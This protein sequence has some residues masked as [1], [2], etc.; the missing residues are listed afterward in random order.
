ME[1]PTLTVTPPRRRWAVLASFGFTAGC[2]ALM[3]MD[4][5]TVSVLSDDVYSISD[6]QL[7]WI[8][9]ISLLTVLPFTFPAAYFLV[10][11]N[12]SA[13]LV[14]VILNVAGA[15]LRMVAVYSRSYDLALVSSVLIGAAASIVICSYTP[16][17]ERWFPRSEQ[18]LATSIA[19]Q[20]NYAGWAVGSL[21]PLFVDGTGE[22]G[23]QSMERFQLAQAILVSLSLPLFLLCYRANPEP[24]T[25]LLAAGSF[26]SDSGGHGEGGAE[27]SPLASV[28]RLG[29]KAQ[30]WVHAIAYSA[31]GGVSFAIP[32]VQDTIFEQ[33]AISAS[34]TLWT[35]FAFIVCGIVAGLVLG[36]SVKEQRLHAPVL[37]ALFTLSSLA[38]TA[39]VVLVYLSPHI[40]RTTLFGLLVLCM[41]LA[42]VG[43]LGFIG[44]ALRTMVD[45]SQPVSEVYSGGS[46]EWL[47][48]GWGALFTQIS[49]PA[50]AAVAASP[51]APPSPPSLPAG[52]AGFCTDAATVG[53][54]PASD[55]YLDFVP[56]AACAWAATLLLVFCAR[57]T[58]KTDTLLNGSGRPS[59][60]L[61]SS[62]H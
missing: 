43:S 25:G 22:A 39:L 41:A 57:Y 2:N 49:V 55:A 40:P 53:L 47:I 19:V 24:A 27:L 5:S 18:A 61:S 4:F 34:C 16:I 58:P 59:A 52:D 3:F 15:W 62:T 11:S 46:V 38:L 33:L 51:P 50:A 45:V 6:D 56:V 20:C 42:G 28:Q 37:R 8:Y 13:S 31:L 1:P 23:L 36:A 26:Y 10:R 60:Q 14:G 30:F 29:C 21:I 12:W 7:N 44:I 48:Q 32:A 54:A 35:N 17:A 9:S